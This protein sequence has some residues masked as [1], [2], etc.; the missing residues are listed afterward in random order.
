[1]ALA[2][3]GLL[4]AGGE[5]GETLGSDLAARVNGVA[6]RA[7]DY[8][9][10]LAGVAS[11]RRNP[12]DAAERR[13]VLD[14]LI[15]EELLVQ[16]GLELGF[17]RH[18]RKIRADLVNAVIGAIAIEAEDLQPSDAELEAFYAEHRDFFT[19]PGR[20]R[21][22]QVFCKA[23]G[24]DDAR[25]AAR[26]AEAARRLRAGDDFTAVRTALGDVEISPVPDVPLP[27]AKLREYLGPTVLAAALALGAGEVSEPV[28]GATG[29]H[30]V[31]VVERE[32]DDAPPA[33]ELR[34]QLLVEYRRRAG[35]RALRAY[36]DDL[37]ARADIAVAEPQP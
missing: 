28:R 23:G 27:A 30:V 6:I 2:A 1:V 19:R 37:R 10:A 24:A 11:D 35:E 8:E 14:R 15:E 13:H 20:L 7:A 31:Q 32:A 33:A 5:G 9:R 18:D 25:A 17:A 21:V 36:L 26:A 34:E 4:R 22:R 16:R 29:Y 3:A 12:L